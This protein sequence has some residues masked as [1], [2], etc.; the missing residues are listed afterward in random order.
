MLMN[1]NTWSSVGRFRKCPLE[2]ALGF[3]DLPHFRKGWLSVPVQNSGCDCTSSCSAA[4]LD[5]TII[6][7]CRTATEMGPIQCALWVFC[8][9]E[10]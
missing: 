4:S 6:Q 1:L 3:K 5:G 7:M 10:F 9:F 8:L 2:V